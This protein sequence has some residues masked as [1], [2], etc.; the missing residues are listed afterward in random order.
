MRPLAPA[1]AAT[2]A[3][4]AALLVVPRPADT[5]EVRPDT[6]T[7]SPVV[8]TA[9]RGAAGTRTAT[10]STTVLDGARLRAAG[11][12]S[13]ADALR[14]VP[15]MT[16]V[17]QGSPGGVTSIFLRGGESDYVRV[18]VDGVPV[19]EPGGFLD[20]AN[21]T[22][23]DVERIEIVRGPS[24]VLYGSEAVSGVIQIFT[25][26]GLQEGSAARGR[27][28]FSAGTQETRDASVSLAG[29]G[30]L[31][32]Y[33]LGAS[34]HRIGGF[35][36]F[37]DR[38]EN[39]S[40]GALVR[41]PR[42]RAMSAHASLRFS[43]GDSRYPTEFTGEA[44][45]SNSSGSERKLAA[46][47]GVVRHV[48]DRLD[49]E[50]LGSSMQV[51]GVNDDPADTPGGPDGDTRFSREA[52]RRGA[53]ARATL[54]PASTA[55]VT[56]GADLEWQRVR[57]QFDGFGTEGTPFTA[58]RWS[59]AAYAQTLGELG[60]AISYSAGVRWDD[61]EFY[62]RHLTYRAGAGARLPAGLRLRAAL[63]TGFKEPTL[64]EA[65]AA[66]LQGIELDPE[67]S[68]GWEAGLEQHL[69][70]DRLVLGATYFDQR[71]EDLIEFVG[72]TEAFEPIY[73]NAAEAISRGAELEGRLR[74]TPSATLAAT[75]TYLHTEVL[76][77]EGQSFQ[78]GGALLRRPRHRATASLELR[79]P[80]A[81]TLRT[82]ANWVG[83]RADVRFFPDFSSE[84][85]TL[86]A[87]LTLDAGGEVELARRAGPL[88]SV[89]L[90]ARVTNL[91][92]E[93]YEAIVGFASPGRVVAAGVRFAF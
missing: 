47:L 32:D 37:N 25:R 38:F 3:L 88:G 56:I 61:N 44:S 81:A 17:R 39:T 54:R 19:N 59:R 21:L 15:G 27:A 89:A 36:P 73:A 6:A 4:S 42:A 31:G 24:S 45:D 5:Q 69:A 79:L 30:R 80:R 68:R 14:M 7:L 34:R 78:V 41:T 74:P 26:G 12:T 63:G 86:P 67:L 62:G 49:L 10:A 71:F 84:R 53:A 91:L 65:S 28:S 93:E 52:W 40:I 75:Y 82:D 22:T 85:V 55:S 43:D 1:S 11:V 77:A 48:G 16:I 50:L 9:T 2:L 92:D 8:V 29:V 33:G 83:E 58:R 87:F 64:D 70:G 90:T 51:E 66:A 23:D 46:G 13:V 35:H 72:Q 76:D 20:A 57:T 18:L 60:P